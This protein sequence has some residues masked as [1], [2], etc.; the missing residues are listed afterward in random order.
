MTNDNNNTNIEQPLDDA[1]KLLE[2]TGEDNPSDVEGMLDNE[3]CKDAC[4]DLWM[5]KN[6]I[7]RHHINIPDVDKEWKKFMN[8]KKEKPDRRYLWGVI[9]G[10]AAS[11]LVVVSL[12]AWMKLHGNNEFIAYRASDEPAVV[13]LHADDMGFVV[14]GKEK[15]PLSQ[16]AGHIS[17][18]DSS[19]TYSNDE[20]EEI[21]QK[22]VLTTP[23]GK[24]FKVTLADGTTVWLNAKSSLSYPTRFIG[25]KRVVTLSGEAYFQVT[26]NEKMPFYIETQNITTKVLGTEFN[27]KAYTGSASQ[28][29]LV[30]GKVNVTL[31]KSKITK[32]LSPGENL[33]IDDNDKVTI[34]NVETDVFYYWKEGYFFFDNTPI[35]DIMKC[36]GEWYNMNVVFKNQEV[37]NHKIH[38]FCDRT[39]TI[40]DALTL[41]NNIGKA[42]AWVDGS[43]I[44]IK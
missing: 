42:H 6:S 40:D 28:V 17:K 7:E 18:T 37:M 43:T 16:L 5:L 27:I 30:K 32:Q 2:Q 34:Q 29:T 35:V 8:D 11:F 31:R 22:H 23:R 3:E 24:T 38:Y 26:R 44:F 36:I 10:V 19:L 39:G 33:S 9:T 21:I 25:N 15:I 41:F 20:T 1:L 14:S 4:K 12:V 13:T